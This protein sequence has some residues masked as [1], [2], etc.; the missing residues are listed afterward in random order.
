MERLTDPKIARL[1]LPTGKKQSLVTDLEVRGF[2]VRVGKASKAYTFNYVRNKKSDRIVIGDVGTMSLDDA[3]EVARTYRRALQAGEDPRAMERAIKRKLSFVTT[4]AKL[5]DH[6]ADKNKNAGSATKNKLKQRR[7]LEFREKY[8]NWAVEEFTPSDLHDHLVTLE[9]VPGMAREVLSSV[10]RIVNFGKVSG[11]L[12]ASVPNPA[13]NVGSFLPFRITSVNSF[14]FCFEEEEMKKFYSAIGE[15]YQDKS[16]SPIA[17]AAI[18]LTLHVGGRPGEVQTL[19]LHEI[20]FES[21]QIVKRDHKTA[22]S[23]GRP[24]IMRL[25][26]EAVA[27]LHR[28]EW[29]RKQRG[30]YVRPEMGD[31]AFPSPGS[32]NAKKPYLSD[33][34]FPLEK[35]C[36]R[37]G[38]QRLT[39]HSLRSGYINFAIDAGVK[40]EHVAQNVGHSSTRTTLEHYVR[41]RLSK[42]RQAAD[43]TGVAFRPFIP[44]TLERITASAINPQIL[45]S[46]DVVRQIVDR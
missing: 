37:A 41:N 11:V 20:D 31:W 6:Y 17:L 40:I 45:R 30:R 44:E 14:A 10:R 25:S 3:R 34:G 5:I 39:P 4:W 26:D 23:S 29:A 35:L 18:E 36:A 9:S 7:M 43:D 42:L 15:A 38:I 24:R 16:I 1:V 19:Q 13:D 21:R 22:K 12:A 2:A 27:V 32:Q 46:S 33:M 8:G 28:A